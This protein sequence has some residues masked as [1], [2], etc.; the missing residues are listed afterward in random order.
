MHEPE[1]RS[2]NSKKTDFKNSHHQGLTTGSNPSTKASLVSPGGVLS[3]P[4]LEMHRGYI[5]IWRKLQDSSIYQDSYAL[6]VFLELLL[7]AQRECDFYKTGFKQAEYSLKSGESVVG[8]HQLSKKL[9]I[10]PSN[11]RNAL[12]RLE[13]KYRCILTKKDNKRTIVTI[14]NWDT[15]QNLKFDADIKRTSKGHQKD[16]KQELENIRNKEYI[17]SSNGATPHSYDI[18]APISYL[19][20]KTNKNF[21]LKNKSTVKLVTARYRE[22]RTLDDFK[23][24]IDAMTVRWGTDPKMMDYLRP[25]TLFNQTNF[26]NYL[27][28]KQKSEFDK[29]WM[30]N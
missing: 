14:L 26:E 19:N 21:S 23:F 10:K 11:I 9:N 29:K 20:K 28:T 5:K 4:G 15:Y 7:T 16:T 12:T 8:R 27:N 24:V 2:F 22:G 13:Q 17:L 6:H 30:T 3:N 25:S 18:E 1:K